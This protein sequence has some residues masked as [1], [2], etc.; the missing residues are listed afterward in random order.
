MYGI[1]SLLRN[2]TI[3][4]NH[5]Y[6]NTYG[7]YLTP[8]ESACNIIVSNDIIANEYG[9]Y[10]YKPTGDGVSPGN[11]TIYLNNFI[12]NVVNAYSN[13]KYAN[14]TWNS[15]VVTYITAFRIQGVLGTT[16]MTILA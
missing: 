1:Y 14:N 15:P 8:V 11:N 10:I 5:I 3:R 7:I 9:I 6:N 4:E 12:G 16:G 13:D 2:S